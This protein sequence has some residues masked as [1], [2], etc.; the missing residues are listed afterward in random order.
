MANYTPKIHSIGV[1]GG[2]QYSSQFL[3]MSGKTSES[4]RIQDG[5]TGELS[6]VMYHNE[7]PTIIGGY[8]E[9]GTV[10]A[11]FP[12]L[13]G[14]RIIAGDR[15]GIVDNYMEYQFLISSEPFRHEITHGL[16]EY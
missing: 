3:V 1:A 7:K 2:V 11:K 12:S 15:T 4:W 5:T 14:W 16:R 8:E 13:K 6:P 10:F 9:D